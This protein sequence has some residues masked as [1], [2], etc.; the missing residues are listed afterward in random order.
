MKRI[1]LLV[2]FSVRLFA[3]VVVSPN[4][5]L[6]VPVVGTT[7]G[8]E[9]ANDI[10]S[11]MSSIDGHDHTPG[12]GVPISSAAINIDSDLSLNGNSL[13]NTEAAIFSAQSSFSTAQSVYVISP[14][15]I[16]NDGNGNVIRI[17]QNGSVSGSSG[18]ITGLPSGTASASYQSVGGTFQFQSATN[19]PANGTF[20][21]LSIAQ[22]TT[23]PN[24]ITLKSPNSLAASYNFTF[25][26]S[27]PSFTGILTM[28]TSG[29]ISTQPASAPSYTSLLT[30][31]SSGTISS[32][33]YKNV[34]QQ[35]FTSG[36]G[37]YTTPS[38]P[39]PI[40][41][42]VV[43]VGGGGGGNSGAT[44]TTTGGDG[45]DSTFGTA[46]IS[47]GG[48]G[49]C[50]QQGSSGPPGG[51][52]SLGAATGLALTGSRGGAGGRTSDAAEGSVGG[53]GGTSALGGAGSAGSGNQVGTAGATNTGSGGGGGGGGAANNAGC[54]GASGGYVDAI[55]T[56]PASSYTYSVGAAGAA[57]TGGNVGGAGGSGIILVTEYYQ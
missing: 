28:S 42:R 47:A 50:T 16:Y 17:T 48:G 35:K 32:A 21:S 19:T 43:A 9:W 6:P 39:T 7:S 41:I 20:A 22:Q 11:C 14:D 34:T 3:E 26:T 38:G 51:T 49:G 57:S 13:T 40:Y 5:N 30:M 46:L 53:D 29:S 10:N 12:K 36:S 8:P 15:L 1:F 27:V 4:M 31:N 25:P 54:G 2:L 37:T 24:T 52:S 33:P 23:N 56:N 45:G 18:T 55:I 44:V